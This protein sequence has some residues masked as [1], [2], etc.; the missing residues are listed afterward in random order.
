MKK[1]D[2]ITRD[3]GHKVC[4]NASLLQDTITHT[5]EAIQIANSLQRM[6]WSWTGGEYL[7]ETTEAQE[8]HANPLKHIV[9]VGI[10]PQ[11]SRYE[12]T[13]L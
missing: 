3:L 4:P 12:A 1:L 10:E 11:S 7:E 5:L 2:P 6:S 9:E 8:D 13:L